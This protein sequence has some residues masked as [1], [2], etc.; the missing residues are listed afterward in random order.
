M[1]S[2]FFDLNNGYASLH[3]LNDPAGRVEPWGHL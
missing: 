1:Q 2:G 3:K